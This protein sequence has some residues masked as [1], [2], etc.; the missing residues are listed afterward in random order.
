M[1]FVGLVWFGFF[2]GKSC[3]AGTCGAVDV[4]GEC[5]LDRDCAGSEDLLR[6]E[7]TAFAR[8]KRKDQVL[9]LLSSLS[10]RFFLLLFF[11]F[12]PA[13]SG[14]GE[15]CEKKDRGKQAPHEE[16][17]D[18]T[19]LMCSVKSVYSCPC[20]GCAVPLILWET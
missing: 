5:L 10:C 12:P 20:L 7:E 1:I 16:G 4:D 9:Q 2:R 6:K 14:S 3:S 11:F 17:T 15:A 18:K 13:P 8:I 19:K